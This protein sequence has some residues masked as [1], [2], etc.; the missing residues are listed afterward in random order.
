MKV[1]VTGGTGSWDRGV[2]PVVIAALRAR[3]HEV[4]NLDRAVPGGIERRGFIKV[5]LTDYGQTF[6]A[7]HG[8]DAVIQLAANG[9]PDWDHVSGAARFHVNTLIAYNVFQAACFLG[10]K[11]VVWASSETVLGFPF[12]VPPAVLPANDD[13]PP[14]PTSS[15]GI[16]KAVTEDLARH[17][18]RQYGVP[19][20]GL[21]FSNIFYDVPGHT[22]SYERI[23]K[24]WDDPH[25]RKFDL[26]GYV[27]SRDTADSCVQ[28][29]ESG[30]SGAEVMTISAADTIMRQPNSELVATCFPG[31]KILPGTGE[32]DTLISIDAARRLIGYDPKWTWRQVLNLK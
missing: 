20:V 31:C 18:N 13:D 1:A 4:T 23:P 22:T 24:F 6:A 15:Y 16:S 25:S 32:H 5:D 28:A 17:M 7:L 12:T 21:R 29:L 30:I 27:D 14:I 8:H 3:G 11:K 2:G 26:W 10:M 19:F 9:E